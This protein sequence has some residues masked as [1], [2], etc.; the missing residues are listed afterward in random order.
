LL[1]RSRQGEQDIFNADYKVTEVL[2]K[3][4]DKL[5]ERRELRHLSSQMRQEIIDR[6]KD[7]IHSL[8]ERRKNGG[9]V[10]ALKFKSR[11]GSIPLKQYGTTYDVVGDK[12]R[13]QNIMHPMRVRGLGQVPLGEVANAT[14]E[15]RDGDYFIHITTYQ[16][17]VKKHFPCLSLG[18]DSGVKNQLTL[19]NGLV[20]KE[21][22]PV[23]KRA[24]HLHREL[25]RRQRYGRNWLKAQLKLNR[26]YD[27][28]TNLRG[29]IRNKVVGR[30]T[31]TYDTIATQKDNIA[32]W[33]RIWGRRVTTTAIGG[34]MSDLR[35]KTHTPVEVDRF[36]A[37]TK[38]CSRCGAVKEIGLEERIY[39]CYRCNLRIDRDLNA[40]IN[41][42]RAVPAERRELTPVDTKTA[43]EMMEYFNGIPN[44]S[45][46]L[47]EETGS[48]VLA[49]ETPE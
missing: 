4:R 16:K 42:W 40:A 21:A 46:S 39:R 36:I 2:V 22:I 33:Q 45:A 13:V 32:G 18:I 26:E 9:R 20:I 1:E 44:L 25:C 37:T 24:R 5:F 41:I 8:S 35:T 49:R 19:S 27:H 15:Q 17:K 11:I 30:L 28:I 43:T 29:D 23:T 48:Q 7:A 38:R 14:L 10:G 47:V 34:I 12:V 6:T 31:S 3:N